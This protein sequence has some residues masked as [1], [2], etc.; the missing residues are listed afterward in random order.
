MAM[1]P[2]LLAAVL[3]VLAMPA[4][5]AATTTD[6]DPQRVHK[7]QTQLQ[8]QVRK[9][10]GPFKDIDAGLQNR[11]IANQD[12]VLELVNGKQSLDE[13]SAEDRDELTTT[14]GDIE[15][16]VTKAK[17]ERQ[18]CRKMRPTGSNRPQ[19][20]CMTAAQHR[21]AQKRAREAMEKRPRMGP[22]FGG[23]L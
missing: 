17:D 15:R 19:V 4:A 14:L 7:E 6:I 2:F 1:K 9:G 10:Q 22:G 3:F 18:V 20:V 8:S 21:E 5:G 23:D 11:I 13:L 12:R 16:L